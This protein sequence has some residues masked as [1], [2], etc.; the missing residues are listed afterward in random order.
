MNIKF[1]LRTLFTITAIF[2]L[3]LGLFSPFGFFR[4]HTHLRP[5]SN[6]EV[7]ID[8]RGKLIYDNYYY[9]NDNYI[10][11]LTSI[12]KDRMMTIG[13]KGI[14]L[15]ATGIDK[16]ISY[17]AYPSDHLNGY[18]DVSAIPS[19]YKACVISYER[20]KVLLIS[21]DNQKSQKE[22]LTSLRPIRNIAATQDGALLAVSYQNT[23]KGIDLKDNRDPY[24]IEI[25]DIKSQQHLKTIKG[26]GQDTACLKFSPNGK[27]LV[28]QCIDLSIYVI[29]A[30]TQKVVLVEN[31]IQRFDSS[32]PRHTNLNRIVFSNDSTLCAVGRRIIDTTLRSEVSRFH[33]QTGTDSYIPIP[34][35]AFLFNNEYYLYGDDTDVSILRIAN[36]E[37]V[38][39]FKPCSNLMT[40]RS[41]AC[42]Q[43]RVY[44]CG[45]TGSYGWSTPQ[46][47]RD[48]IL[49]F[50]PG[51][52]IWTLQRY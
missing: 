37:V 46:E 12:S 48:L 49:K 3:M 51:F 28:V 38:A 13:T 39:S 45:S 4:Y 17:F 40:I 8:S 1:T 21:F 6:L 10:S 16:P 15:Y 22:L 50:K 14:H 31:G 33:E 24:D 43:D 34:A 23:S 36:S 52:A 20:D 25:F 30:A 27:Y 47:T 7:S 11:Q 18:G 41:I 35:G 42:L 19:Q 44:I 29:E 2:A 32:L 26:V 5:P 9:S